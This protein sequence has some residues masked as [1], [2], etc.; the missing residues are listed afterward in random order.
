MSPELA[1][2]SQQRSAPSSATA[3]CGSSACACPFYRAAGWSDEWSDLSDGEPLP[4]ERA[5]LGRGNDRL[6]LILLVP[7]STSAH[8][9]VGNRIFLSPIVGNDAFPDNAFN[10]TARRSDYEFSLLPELEKQLSNSS[11]LLFTGG[12]ARVNASASQQDT[13]GATDFSMYFRLA[14]YKS[15]AN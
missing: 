10:L 3:T 13:T 1:A 9:V 11:S 7:E 2:A 14:V 8:G 15:A 4:I 12:W 5:A 6:T